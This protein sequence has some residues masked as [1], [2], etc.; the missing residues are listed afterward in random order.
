[1]VDVNFAMPMESDQMTGG[2]VVE[3]ANLTSGRLADLLSAAAAPAQPH[4]LNWEYGARTAFHSAASSWPKTHR[5][6][7]RSPA[8]LAV[9]TAAGLF[10]TTTSLAAATGLPAPAAR[11]VDR[12]LSHVGITI[13]PPGSIQASATR[14]G[15]SAPTP[16]ANLVAPGSSNVR[17][18]PAGVVACPGAGSAHSP[19]STNQSTGSTTSGQCGT[20][21]ALAGHQGTVAPLSTATNGVRIR[22]TGAGT[23]AGTNRGGNQ[24]TAGGT[25]TNRG[26]NQGTGGGTGTNR[27][28]NQGTG[29]GTG[30]NRGGNQGTGGGTGTNRGGNQGTAGGTCPGNG[31]TTTTTT[32]TGTGSTTITV[33]GTGSTT[34]TVTGTGSTTITTVAGAGKCGGHHHHHGTGG[35]A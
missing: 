17:A 15:A 16:A 34:I 21:Q 29:G 31:S 2:K 19:G 27:G 6:L 8:I 7:L 18:H 20:P 23:G 35:G 22:W 30:T 4:E 14:T 13:Q 26:G 5:R 1:M 12:V 3:L 33:T 32:V 9:L 24:G 25:G 10:A 11:V 28:G